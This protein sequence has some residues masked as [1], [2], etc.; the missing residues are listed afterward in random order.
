[1][2]Q[3]SEIS[4]KRFPGGLHC[5]CTGVVLMYIGNISIYVKMIVIFAL[6]LQAMTMKSQVKYN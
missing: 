1:M 5:I 4:N 6:L 3:N 2:R